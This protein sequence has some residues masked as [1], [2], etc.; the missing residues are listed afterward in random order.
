[1]MRIGAVARGGVRVARDVRVA[2][3]GVGVAQGF[4]P[5]IALLALGICTASL[6][7]QEIAWSSN[8][9]DVQGTRYLP[10]PEINRDSV[11]RL[12]VAWADD[13]GET[14]LRHFEATR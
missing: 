7:A 13:T 9:R 8:G 6:A 14:E 2:Q 5:A 4:S 1:M 3:R 10:A 11:S 12:E